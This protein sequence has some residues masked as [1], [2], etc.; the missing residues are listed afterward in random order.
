MG[1]NVPA[2][3][4]L[5]KGFGK[6]AAGRVAVLLK[7]PFT[8]HTAFAD[9]GGDGR[10]KRIYGFVSLPDGRD[11]AS[12]LVEEGLA[13]AFGVYHGTPDGKP[14]REYKE[15][16]RDLELQAAKRSSG[17]WAKTN[18]EKLPEERR[19]QRQEEADP[20]LATGK[21]EPPK[22]M[23]LDPN[24]AARD[25]LLRLPGIG[26]LMANRIIEARPYETIEDLLE[27]SGLGKKTLE[28][29]RPHLVIGAPPAK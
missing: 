21:A 4:E 25:D 13:R 15:A 19:K 22:G 2:C 6:T 23:L 29:L 14:L 28:R 9:A 18:W 20:D 10:H 5:A 1:G 16:M 27:V 7:S 3:I 11:L 8:V 17:I 12:V 24:T 26:E